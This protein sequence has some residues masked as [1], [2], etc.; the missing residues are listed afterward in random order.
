MGIKFSLFNRFLD[1]NSA[2]LHFEKGRDFKL[3]LSPVKVNLNLAS[4]NHST[5]LLHNSIIIWPVHYMVDVTMKFNVCTRKLA[6]KTCYVEVNARDQCE[7]AIVLIWFCRCWGGDEDNN[8]S[9]QWHA[10]VHQQCVQRV[11][12][13]GKHMYVTFWYSSGPSWFAS[14]TEI[15]RWIALESCDWFGDLQI[16]LS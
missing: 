1:M 15:T 10:S 11:Y 14:F 9:W 7:L 13:T 8:C 5:T 6:W 16:V 4:D 2:Q 3:W 12:V